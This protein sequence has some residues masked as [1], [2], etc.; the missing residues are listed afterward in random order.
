MDET[1]KQNLKV[2]LPL[3][4]SKPKNCTTTAIDSKFFSKGPADS[5]PSHWPLNQQFDCEIFLSSP[6]LKT[7]KNSFNLLSLE[8]STVMEKI[9]LKCCQIDS[10][11]LILNLPTNFDPEAS[12]IPQENDSKID[13][14]Q[15]D[16]L[17]SNNQFK[18][19]IPYTDCQNETENE[20]IDC[21]LG[22][23]DIESQIE[24]I[25]RE[26]EGYG[27]GFGEGEGEEDRESDEMSISDVLIGGGDGGDE[28]LIAEVRGEEGVRYQVRWRRL[29][30]KEKYTKEE[31]EMLES[32]D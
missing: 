13:K 6:D 27:Y 30:V 2:E 19:N 21:V 24:D 25:Y 15:Q 14:D 11:L 4:P 8:I 1:T 18:V 28:D 31:K 32:I 17:S 26:I 7:H 12:I 29:E 23:G 20:N 9:P 3:G 5:L 22:Q 10:A 16:S